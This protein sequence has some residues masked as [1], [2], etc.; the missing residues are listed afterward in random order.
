[1]DLLSPEKEDI[2]PPDGVL[3][4]EVEVPLNEGESAFDIL[5]RATLD[6]AIH[7]EHT[8]PPLYKSSY[9]EGIGNIYEFDCGELSGWMYR[10][11]GEYPNYGAGKHPMQDGDLLEWVYTCDLGRDI[12]AALINQ[13]Q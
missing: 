13:K 11:N 5:L 9:I 10:V 3:L 12:G 8:S 7:M 1:M 6:R 4:A 2:L